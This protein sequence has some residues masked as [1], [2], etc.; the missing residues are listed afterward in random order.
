MVSLRRHIN[1]VKGDRSGRSSPGIS[2]K[3]HDDTFDSTTFGTI[4]TFVEQLVYLF[5]RGVEAQV[6]DLPNG[7]PPK[8]RSRKKTSIR[9]G[10]KTLRE[11]RPVCSCPVGPGNPCSSTAGREAVRRG[12]SRIVGGVNVQSIVTSRVSTA[13]FLPADPLLD[14]KVI[15]RL[16][17]THET[18]I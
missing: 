10:Y 17:T 14:L 4:R 7:Q 15:F 2:I 13:K 12:P 1:T 9:K 11:P 5:L 18:K 6:A 8:I 16:D 3:A